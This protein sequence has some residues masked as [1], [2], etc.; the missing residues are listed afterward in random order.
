[1]SKA[2]CFPAIST[3]CPDGDGAM[4]GLEI[5]QVACP[6]LPIAGNERK[7]VS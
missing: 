6:W 3:L 2:P 1:M 7:R 4:I 5:V